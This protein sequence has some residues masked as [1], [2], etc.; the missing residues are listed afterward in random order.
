MGGTA[1]V[2]VPV[3]NVGTVIVPVIVA[4]ML[5]KVPVDIVGMLT[6]PV[7]VAGMQFVVATLGV[8]VVLQPYTQINK[9]IKINNFAIFLFCFC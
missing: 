5:G 1:V 3:V 7:I 4:G 9:T 6:V 2:N 8:V